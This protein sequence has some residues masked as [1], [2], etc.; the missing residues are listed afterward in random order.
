LAVAEKPRDALY[1]FE[2]L[3]LQDFVG[4]TLQIQAVFVQG[5]NVTLVFL[6]ICYA[7]YTSCETFLIGG[8]KHRSVLRRNFKTRSTEYIAALK[9]EVCSS[10]FRNL[11]GRP[12]E[13]FQVYIFKSVQ[14]LA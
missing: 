3:A 14:I 4:I 11:K 8:T 12:K 9:S 7:E 6:S 10:V 2:M 5:K 13:T 1:H